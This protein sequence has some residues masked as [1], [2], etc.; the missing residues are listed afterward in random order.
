MV[1][2]YIRTALQQLAQNKGRSMLTMLGIIIGIGSVIFIMTVGEI[3][4]N[5]LLSQISQFGTNV[6]EVALPSEI[7][8]GDSDIELNESDV[9]ALY[10]SPL[11]PELTGVSAGFTVN[12]SVEIDA[13]TFNATVFGDRPE[14]FSVNNLN[15]LK[16]RAFTDADVNSATNVV[17]ID[18][19]TAKDWFDTTDVVGKRVRIGGASISIIGVMEDMSFGPG[20]F[21]VA[22]IYMP[23]STVKK[24]YAD[25]DEQDIVSFLL[26]AFEPGSDAQSFQNRLN[27]VLR[28]EKGLLDNE[29]DPFIMIGREQALGIVDSVLLALQAF[30]S[31]VAAISLVVGGIGIM[32]IMLVTVKERTKEIGLRKAIGAKNHSILVQFLIESVVLTTVGGVV[33]IVLGVGLSLAGVLAINAFQPDWGVAFVFVPEALLIA[34]GVAMTVGIIFGLYPAFKASRLHPIEALRYE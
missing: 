20:G 28:E 21:G 26:V 33:G 23:I 3:A 5:F 7:G 25:S 27:Y 4:K 12:E 31:A 18:E 11:L 29:D 10:D 17:V 34:T 6:V 32:N 1:T 13:E 14:F 16:G 9:D 24:L 2:T 19:T 8:L 22:V 30:V 15:V